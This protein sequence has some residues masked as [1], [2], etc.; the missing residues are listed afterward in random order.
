MTGR[1]LATAVLALVAGIVSV[2]M[3][4][5]PAAADPAEPTDYRSEVERI[6][7]AAAG[8]TIDVVGGDGF[9]DLHV[10]RGHEVVVEG[11]EGEPW[12]RIS[13]D[14]TVE[15]NIR[16]AAT[17]LNADRY[18]SVEAPDLVDPDAP[19]EWTVIGDGGEHVWHDHRIHWMSP[20]RPPG[21]HP[22]DTIFDDWTVPMSVDG[23][24]VTVHGRLVWVHD[25]NPLVWVAAVVVA[26]VGVLVAARRRSITVAAVATTVVAVLA[27]VVGAGQLGATPA[28]AGGTRLVVIVPAIAVVAGA[29]AIALRRRPAAVVSLLAA[30]AALSGW[31]LLR[32]GVLTN[33]VLPTDLPADLD[34]SVTAAA[35]GV[36]IAAVAIA[37]SVPNPRTTPPARRPASPRTGCGR[38]RRSGRRRRA[39]RRGCPARR[40]G[41]PRPRG[42][43]RRRGWWRAGGR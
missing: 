16:S 22:G 4:A 10:D 26:L 8:V 23:Q 20:D 19:P 35:I 11:Y 40:R 36:T 17:Y 13:A 34:R 1:R 12:L 18:A 31:A 7:P 21:R 24:A 14:G 43:R 28:E 6:E 32:L 5:A 33:P 25:E 29:A 38:A 30:V 41:R 9:L 42:W 3:S 2:V 27:V 15:Q 39:A 37:F